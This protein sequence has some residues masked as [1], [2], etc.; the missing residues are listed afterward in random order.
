VATVDP[1]ATPA[2]ALALDA[3][4]LQFDKKILVAPADAAVTVTLINNEHGVRHNF[5]VYK[6]KRASEKIFVGDLF[7]GVA[8]MDYTFATPAPGTYFF[9]CDI[10]PDSMTGTF[11]TK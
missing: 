10:H 4:N 1:N 7:S 6:S 8:T 9:R 5:A 2:A 11:V 3:R